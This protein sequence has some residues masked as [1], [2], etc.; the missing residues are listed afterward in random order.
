MSA[1]I[2]RRRW[3][4]LLSGEAFQCH[5]TA[6]DYYF[7]HRPQEYERYKQHTEKQKQPTL[8]MMH[9]KRAR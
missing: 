3:V 8:E 7:F 4:K 5:G 2:T 1:Y 6:A 9:Q